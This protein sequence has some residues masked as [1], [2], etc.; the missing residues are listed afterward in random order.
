MR[1]TFPGP[2][3]RRTR[4]A[5]STASTRVSLPE[6]QRLLATAEPLS[7]W[8]ATSSRRRAASRSLVIYVLCAF[9]AG[10]YPAGSICHPSYH[11]ID[12]PLIHHLALGG[13]FVYTAL[14]EIAL[15]DVGVGAGSVSDLGDAQGSD[16]WQFVAR[17]MCELVRVC[18]VWVCGSRALGCK[19]RLRTSQVF[20]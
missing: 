4:K 14:F 17:H 2:L 16:A 8:Q 13:E 10:L 19:L 11:R 7:V 18:F 12:E 1:L 20:L 6:E 5:D 15:C 9:G 3:A